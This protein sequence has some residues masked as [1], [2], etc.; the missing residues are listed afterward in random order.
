MNLYMT[1]SKDIPNSGLEFTALFEL[2][3]NY[4][5]ESSGCCSA[6]NDN[7]RAFYTALGF[8]VDQRG[9]WASQQ[10]NFWTTT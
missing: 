8:S 2:N 9:V 3:R 10:P 5:F 6:Y 1:N 7:D 4:P